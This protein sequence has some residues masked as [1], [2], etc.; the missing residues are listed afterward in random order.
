MPVSHCHALHVSATAFVTLQIHDVQDL[1]R[2]FTAITCQAG[3]SHSLL[4]NACQCNCLIML[5]AA[6]KQREK[7][8]QQ[9]QQELDERPWIA[10]RM[11]EE[12]KQA[13]DGSSTNV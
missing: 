2:R 11:E 13:G 1:L 4:D 5:E 12:R 10:R 7:L 6:A 9:Q 8:A 3:C